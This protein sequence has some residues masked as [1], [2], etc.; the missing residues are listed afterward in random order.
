MPH[1]PRERLV[2][3]AHL[4]VAQVHLA[5]EVVR[6]ATIVVQTTEVCAAH[7][8]DLEFLVTRGA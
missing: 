6:K 1:L 8:A 7:V 4:R 3:L 2:G 5:V